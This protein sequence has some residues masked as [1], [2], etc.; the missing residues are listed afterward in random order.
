MTPPPSQRKEEAEALRLAL[1]AGLASVAEAVAWADAAIMADARPDAAVI[2]VA[3]AGSPTMYEMAAL[4][5]GVPG[6]ADPARVIRRHL[7]D[8]LR[9]LD[10][11]LEHTR[12]VAAR[13][14]TMAF[15][16]TLADP[17]FDARLASLVADEYELAST[18]IYGSEAAA[19]DTIR[20]YLLTHAL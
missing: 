8:L 9:A 6:V 7:G 10:R 14:Y 17:R 5:A 16:G 12:L 3:L 2:D 1:L 13:L 11:D 20:Q 15:D 19:R 18:D 4:L